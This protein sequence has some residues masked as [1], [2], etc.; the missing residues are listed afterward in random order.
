MSHYFELANFLPIDSSFEILEGII[1]L[2]IGYYA[3]KIQRITS[4]KKYVYFTWAFYLMA[5]SFFL[6]ALT[7][8]LSYEEW[9]SATSPWVKLT[10]ISSL[11]RWGYLAHV[12]LFT[13]GL[14][15]V[16]IVAFDLCE[17]SLI[18]LVYL[19]ALAAVV[20][21]LNIYLMFH[22]VI[23]LALAY[24]VP[25]FYHNYKK[26]KSN[27]AFIVFTAFALLFFSHI[28]FILVYGN[29]YFYFIAHSIQLASFALLLFSFIKIRRK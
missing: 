25:K 4:E 3:H 29:P 9:V 11:Y 5:A 19:L 14:T 6:A 23:I 12:V 22:F 8:Y 21:S 26:K 24:V 2:F 15:T 1:A 17:R 28:F 27:N 18:S 16:T 13:L 7:N 20:M 10:A